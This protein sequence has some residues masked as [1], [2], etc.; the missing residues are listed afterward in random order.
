MKVTLLG[1]RGSVG[2]AGPDTVRYG[3]DTSAVEVQADDGSLLLLDAGSGVVHSSAAP[4]GAPVH[5]F[6]TH[7]H[8]DHI[9]G[10]GFL[11][12]LFNPD[13][14]VHV[15]GP[16]SSTRSLA[17]R[18][19][20]YLSPPLFPVHLRD[21]P[22]VNL[23]EVG[24]T[25][26]SIGPF[27]VTSDFIIHPGRTLGVRVEADGRSLAYM[28]D[29]EPA[30]GREHLTSGP[31]WTSGYEL[32]RGVD[33]LIHDTQYT[34]EEYRQRIGWGH[35]TLTHAVDFASMAGV[36]R[37]MTFHHEP[38]HSDALIDELMRDLLRDRDL[39]FELVP[40]LAR[41]STEV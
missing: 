11:H 33:L 10:L 5:V 23:H 28:P 4:T 30:L 22:N 24:S 15:C 37:L 25:R 1:T 8:M 21:L 6:L 2:R 3:G 26:M 14:E 19:G 17:A 31:T 13:I 29:H 35:S 32:A 27:S 41:S 38:D 36:G 7:L 40:G 34:D 20:R 16:V 18:L 12:P 9:Q 39:P